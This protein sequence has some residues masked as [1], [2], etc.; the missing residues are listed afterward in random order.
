MASAPMCEWFESCGEGRGVHGAGSMP[1]PNAACQY[2]GA[3][4]VCENVFPSG[5]KVLQCVLQCVLQF[6][7]LCVTECCSVLH[8]SMYILAVAK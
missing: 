6:V 5:C 8:T 4:V 3:Y 7:V 1:W 2:A